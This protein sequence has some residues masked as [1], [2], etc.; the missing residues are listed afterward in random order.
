MK[1]VQLLID[2]L[3]LLPHPEGGYFKET[4]RS[5]SKISQEC[6]GNDFEGSRNYATGIYYL[7]ESGDYSAFHKI[8]QDEMWHFY[9]GDAIELVTIN[10]DGVLN[11]IYI[12]SDIANNEQLQYVVSKNVWFAARVRKE[13]TYALAGCTVSPGFDFRDF[14]LGSYD[15]LI[16]LFPQHEAYIKQFTRS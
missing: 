5:S 15:Q 13:H 10:K 8:K 9:Q 1:N 3:G 4:Y 14:E 11:V 7:L 12:G 16:K 2:K 6:L